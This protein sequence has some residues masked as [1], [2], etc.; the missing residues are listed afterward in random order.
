M[1]TVFSRVLP[2]SG[3]ESAQVASSVPDGLR[4]VARQ[5]ILDVRGNVHAYELLFRTGAA[6]V[7]FD[8]DGDAATR[9]VLDN[10]VVFGVERLADG[11]P[12]FVN[13][14][15]E[16]LLG[17]F[18][19]VLPPQQTVLEVLETLEPDAELVKACR[20]LKANGYRIA[21]DD[22]VWHPAWEP[23]LDLADYVKLELNTTTPQQRASLRKKIGSR[24]IRLILERVETQS[25]FESARREGFTLFQ[26]FY[27]CRPQTMENRELPANRVIHMQILQSVLQRPL[28]IK[29]ISELVK[30]EPALTYRLLRIANSPI[31]ATRQPVSSIH[32]ALVMI[33][34]DMFRRVALLATTAELKGNR[35]SELLRMAFVRSRFC[36]LAAEMAG[37]DATEQYLLGMFSLLPAMMRVPMESVAKALPLRCEVYLALLGERNA[38][39]ALLS[40]V[41]SFELGE[42]ES[43]DR[44]ALEAGLNE[45]LLPKAYG[46]A[47]LWAESNMKLAAK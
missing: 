43:C 47:L 39:R 25:E 2:D 12:I 37:Q 14:T 5:P 36:E 17:G 23:L 13:C 44:I 15:R 6:S 28:D 20:E 33:G 3:N 30:R 40:W 26:G 34:D 18:V 11:Q 22:F 46:E 1:S 35:P 7:A 32:G 24:P 4:Y 10:T 38:E 9:T 45:E 16:A 31:Y 21:L 8:G 27:F 42:W 41:E 29:K 19:K